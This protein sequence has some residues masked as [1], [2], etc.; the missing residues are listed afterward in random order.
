MVFEAAWLAEISRQYQLGWRPQSRFERSVVERPG[1]LI[2]PTELMNQLRPALQA[3]GMREDAL[4][5]LSSRTQELSVAIEAPERTEVRQLDY[6]AAAGRFTAV[7]LAGAGHATEQRAVVTGRVYSTVPVPVL[8]RAINPGDVIR[9]DDV[10]WVNIRED[11]FRHEFVTDPTQLIGTSPRVRL[12]AG[13]PVRQ[14]DT[15]PPIV[16]ARNATVSIVLETGTMRF[17]VLGRALDEGARGQT[18]RITNLQ[19]R[20]TIEAVVVGPDQGH[21]PSR[22]PTSP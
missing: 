22:Q 14:G 16:V 7:V 18:I 13:E 19:S 20:Q 1:R 3:R 17:T 15:R 6:D 8:R 9:R 2:T 21:D 12:R 10:T 11:Q 4:I 5:E